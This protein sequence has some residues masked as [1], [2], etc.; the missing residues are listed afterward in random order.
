MKVS[1]PLIW[2]LRKVVGGVVIAKARRALARFKDCS[3]ACRAT[4]ER[5]LLEKIGRNADSDFGRAHRFSSIHTVEE[6]RR[7]V[8]ITQYEYYEPYIERLKRGEVRALFGSGQ[9]LLMFALTS[10]TTSRPKYIP[11]TDVALREY[12]RGWLLWGLHVFDRYRSIFTG[13]SQTFQVASDWEEFR[14]EGGIPCGSISGLTA[15]MHGWVI[16]R[17]Y[18]LPPILVRVKDSHARYY[19][20]LRLSL[21]RPVA[22]AIAPN[23]STLLTIARLGDEEKEALLRDLADGTLDRRY[24]LPS[25]VRR[26][27]EPYLRKRHQ[28]LVQELERVVEREGHL[29]PKHYWPRL[30]LLA[31]WTGGTVG[32]YLQDYPQ[33]FGQVPVR[34]IGLIAT[35]GRMTIPIQDSTPAGVLDIVHG[36]F[37][38]IPE[39]EIDSPSP[40]VLLADELQEGK[41]YYI[42]LTTST[43]LYRY[44]IRDVV[45][46]VGWYYGTPMLE[47]LHKGAHIANLTGEKITEYQVVCAVD[48]SM[49]R[50]GLRCP[51]YTLAPVWAKVPY[52]AL[53]MEQGS[54]PDAEVAAKLAAMVDE[55]LCRSNLEYAH[56]RESLRLGPVRVRWVPNG[57]WEALRQRR[58]A[59][60]GGTLEQYKHPCLVP[61][62]DFVRQFAATFEFGPSWTERR[63]RSAAS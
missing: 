9:K 39:E 24:E 38:F 57:T 50:L 49:Q 47:F 42:L 63:V 18:C 26:D 25:P 54:V 56:K 48:R 33:Y 23:P 21:P 55:E 35:E 43:G 53:L 30:T 8:P 14:T 7:Q 15:A 31:N 2:V 27:L 5:V 20:A 22:M 32:A 45:R 12:R 46:C 36:F 61:K 1:T 52:Y 28:K 10:G 34:D 44:D 17:R 51:T 60:H 40:T 6:F 19:T 29:Y 11:I 13:D 37:E 62:L 4:Q 16:R 3:Q 41:N 59:L 58:I